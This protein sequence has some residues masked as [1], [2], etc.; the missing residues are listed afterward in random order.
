MNRSTQRASRRVSRLAQSGRAALTTG[1]CLGFLALAVGCGASHGSAPAAAS[2]AASTAQHAGPTSIGARP[3]TSGPANASPSDAAGGST[4]DRSPFAGATG[5][6]G[7]TSNPG[8]TSTQQS[9]DIAAIE[10]DLT[11]SGAAVSQA[12]NDLNAAATA[13]AQNDNP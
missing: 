6:A 2:A 10:Q 3:T 11:S 8:L 9:Q 13:Q 12:G 1:F 5:S 7:S 4:S